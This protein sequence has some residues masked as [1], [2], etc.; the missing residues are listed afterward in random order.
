MN[1]LLGFVIGTAAVIAFAL[2]VLS[3][4]LTNL[5]LIKLR[6][7]IDFLKLIDLKL[8]L[9]TIGRNFSIIN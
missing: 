6:N 1:E 3:F 4:I 5:T 7:V 2:A 9:K 8:I